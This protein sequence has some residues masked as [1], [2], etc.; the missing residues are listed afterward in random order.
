MEFILEP[1]YKIFSQVMNCHLFIIIILMY[2]AAIKILIFSSI[3][4][5][6]LFVPLNL[7]LCV[8]YL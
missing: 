7:V 1:L 2:F 8:D 5:F 6:T 4:L 3:Y